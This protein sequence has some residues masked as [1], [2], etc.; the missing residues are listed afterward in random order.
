MLW[1]QKFLTR[2]FAPKSSPQQQRARQAL[3]L[4]GLEHL[5]QPVVE[6]QVHLPK[7]QDQ[8]PQP[9]HHT[10]LPKLRLQT[11]NEQ[12]HAPPADEPP[13]PSISPE[14]RSR[15]RLCEARD[16]VHRANLNLDMHRKRHLD[17]VKEAKEPTYYEQMLESRRKAKAARSAQ[18][19][20]VSVSNPIRN[21]RN[22]SRV[23]ES[24]TTSSKSDVPVTPKKSQNSHSSHSSATPPT[25]SSTR[26]QFVFFRPHIEGTPPEDRPELAQR[27]A[28]KMCK[29][30][31][32]AFRHVCDPTEAALHRERKEQRKANL[33]KYGVATYEDYVQR[34]RE[35]ADAEAGDNSPDRLS[36]DRYLRY[37][38]GTVRQLAKEDARYR[39]PTAN[40]TQ[41]SVVEK[42]SE[43]DSKQSSARLTATNVHNH[44]DRSSEG[45]KNRGLSAKPSRTPSVPTSVG[46]RQVNSPERARQKDESYAKYR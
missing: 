38:L 22:R 5:L 43:D 24:K 33:R 23:P 21:S 1:P 12:S 4:A 16:F 39:G 11:T 9:H 7:I 3:N 19:A 42:A 31:A 44:S 6:L 10:N 26:G 41:S 40:S 25:T 29:W 32:S 34:N 27:I 46:Y 45:S 30:I 37:R 18:A 15:Q 20:L 14:E 17:V 28:E 13:P 36:R 8:L 2:G 35:T